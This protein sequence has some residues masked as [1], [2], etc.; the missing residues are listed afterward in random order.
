MNCLIESSLQGLRKCAALF[1]LCADLTTCLTPDVL[2]RF[3]HLAVDIAPISIDRA[4]TAALVQTLRTAAADAIAGDELDRCRSCVLRIHFMGDDAQ[5]KPAR[6]RVRSAEH[7]SELQS[8]LRH[9]Y[10]VF[11]LNKN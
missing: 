7:T 8:L 10:A 11:C 1:L 9:S 4:E 2:I 5:A 3:Q 6:R